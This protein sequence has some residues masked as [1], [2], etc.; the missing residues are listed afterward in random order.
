MFIEKPVLKQKK[1][2]IAPPLRKEGSK[3]AKN[4]LNSSGY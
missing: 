4:L 3:A 1:D 2:S